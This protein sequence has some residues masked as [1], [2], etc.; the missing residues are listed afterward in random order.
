MLTL[1][2]FLAPNETMPLRYFTSAKSLTPSYER[3]GPPESP[4]QESFPEK[5]NYH[6]KYRD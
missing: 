3:R 2:H 5:Y 6:K 1:P 4:E